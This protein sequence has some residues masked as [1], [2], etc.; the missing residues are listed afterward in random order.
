MQDREDASIIDIKMG[1]STVTCNIKANPS[2]MGKRLNKDQMTTTATLGMRIVGYVI[3]N[4]ERRIEEKFY[5]FP[6]VYKDQ[7]GRV[8]RK[9]FSYPRSETQFDS[10][11]DIQF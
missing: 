9:L 1:T 8:F 11:T 10:G 6:Y 7:I 3:K 4:Q 2:R 5:K